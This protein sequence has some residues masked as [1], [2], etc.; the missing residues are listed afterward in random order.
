MPRTSISARFSLRQR[1]SNV[2]CLHYN[3]TDP[4]FSYMQNNPNSLAS[5]TPQDDWNDPFFTECSSVQ[6]S[7]FKTNALRIF[8]STYIYVNGAGLYSFF[9][10]YDSACIDTTSCDTY[11]VVMEQ[12]EGIHMYGLNTVAAVN[13][14]VVDGVALAPGMSNVNTFCDTVMLFEYS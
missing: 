3:S 9:Q 7:C 10:N 11:K 1:K 14:A 8:N 12:S 13:M 4:F 6:T 2:S 5:F